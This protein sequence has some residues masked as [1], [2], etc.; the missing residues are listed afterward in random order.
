MAA[1]N[2]SFLYNVTYVC[3]HKTIILGF[4]HGSMGVKRSAIQCILCT[5]YIIAKCA[6]IGYCTTI[7]TRYI[8]K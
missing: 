1:G 2:L 5:A 8:V 6:S 4:S 7:S 3:M